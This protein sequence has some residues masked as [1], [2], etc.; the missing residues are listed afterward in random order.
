MRCGSVEGQGN[1]SLTSNAI[2][3]ARDTA[4]LLCVR[5][6]MNEKKALAL[7]D[8]RF[9][10][11]HAAFVVGVDRF[12]VFVKR[13]LI[14]IRA[15]NQQ[16]GGIGVAQILASIGFLDC[17][18]RRTLWIARLTQ[19]FFALRLLERVPDAAQRNLPSDRVAYCLSTITRARRPC[20]KSTWLSFVVVTVRAGMCAGK[21]TTNEAALR[22]NAGAIF[23]E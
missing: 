16:L 5:A 14:G 22:M 15:I 23:R 10:F 7:E 2:A 12:S 9:E 20:V 11:D 4:L 13:L 6:G 3:N 17:G 21:V 18:N 1:A 8:S 19:R